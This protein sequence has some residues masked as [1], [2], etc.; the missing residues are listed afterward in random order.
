MCSLKF[1]STYCDVN[2][3]MNLFKYQ[4]LKIYHEII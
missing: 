1:K 4:Y 3:K 2:I